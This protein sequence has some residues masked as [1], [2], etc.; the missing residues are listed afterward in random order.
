MVKAEAGLVTSDKNI[1]CDMTFK[2][3][4]AVIKSV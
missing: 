3:K 2:I 1:G 4:E